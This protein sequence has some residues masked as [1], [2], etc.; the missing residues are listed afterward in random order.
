MIKQRFEIIL[1]TTD[2]RGKKHR[3]QREINLMKVSSTGEIASNNY[4]PEELKGEFEK[5]VVLL[6]TQAR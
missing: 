6:M 4:I 5:M 2:S 1:D 3:V